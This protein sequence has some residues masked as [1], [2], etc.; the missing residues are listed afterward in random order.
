RYHSVQHSK[1]I[2]DI[3]GKCTS[4][5]QDVF[6]C[7]AEVIIGGDSA[8]DLG[9]AFLR[10][11]VPGTLEAQ[12]ERGSGLRDK[13]QLTQKSLAVQLDFAHELVE[14]VGAVGQLTLHVACRR[15]EFLSK[16]LNQ[17]RK[18]SYALQIDCFSGGGFA[19]AIYGTGC[20]HCTHL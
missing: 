11:L 13:N 18:R 17:T 10:I 12:R 4:L 9:I 3:S 8:D 14:R 19:C 7:H 20:S 6:N 16:K 2:F 5:W 15:P 1:D